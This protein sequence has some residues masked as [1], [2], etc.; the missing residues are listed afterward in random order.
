MTLY[1]V[2]KIN[3]KTTVSHLTLS[4]VFMK[5]L[6]TEN[7][8]QSCMDSTYLTLNLNSRLIYK[9]FLKLS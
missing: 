5:K 7:V 8:A 9:L 4:L 2:E 3:N 6:S 1:Y